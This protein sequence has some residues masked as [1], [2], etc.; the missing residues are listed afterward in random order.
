M[1]L[2]RMRAGCALI[3]QCAKFYGVVIKWLKEMASTLCV[4]LYLWYPV[5]RQRLAD[6]EDIRAE[7]ETSWSACVMLRPRGGA[8]SKKV[9]EE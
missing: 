2:I 4:V 6:Q 8:E 5:S 3:R 7:T 1:E 9:A